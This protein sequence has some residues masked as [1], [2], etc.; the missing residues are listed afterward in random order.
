MCSCRAKHH[1]QGVG[2][3]GKKTRNQEKNQEKNQEHKTRNTTGVSARL[4]ARLLARKRSSPPLESA[5]PENPPL[6]R[7]TA[8]PK[9]QKRAP[10][11]T[12]PAPPPP[13]QPQPFLIVSLAR[14]HPFLTS[15]PRLITHRPQLRLR[16][17]RPAPTPPLII[18]RLQHGQRLF[19]LSRPPLTRGGAKRRAQRLLLPEKMESAPF[20][21]APSSPPKKWKAHLSRQTKTRYVI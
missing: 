11:L 6:S 14:R 18:Y 16:A 3:R 20:S 12:S 9:K 19:S 1:A 5:T 13:T 8:P 17:P 10:C 15:P 2:R 7:K 21:P 4:S